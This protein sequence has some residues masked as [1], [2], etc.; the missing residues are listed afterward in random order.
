MVLGYDL[1]TWLEYVA[2]QIHSFS[3]GR[4][5]DALGDTVLR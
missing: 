5:V 3:R 2:R 1:L 4:F